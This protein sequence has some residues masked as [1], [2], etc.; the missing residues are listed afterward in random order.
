[1][2]TEGWFMI[3]F[4]AIAIVVLI[5]LVKNEKIEKFGELPANQTLAIAQLGDDVNNLDERTSALESKLSK[6]EKEINKSMKEVDDA[7]TGI[8]MITS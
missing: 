6:Q 3:L 1:M 4:V 2:K 7:T 8:Q 5:L